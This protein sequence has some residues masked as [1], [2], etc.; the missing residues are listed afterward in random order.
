LI[1]CAAFPWQSSAHAESA[2]PAVIWYRSTAD[3]PDGKSFLDQLAKRTTMARLAAVGD[4]VEFVVTLGKTDNHSVGRLERQSERGT[5]AI[6]EVTGESCEQVADALALTLAL[7]I[8]PGEDRA[9][10]EPA[11]AP[12]RAAPASEA[13]GRETSARPAPRATDRPPPPRRATPQEI[14]TGLRA[15]VA[16]GVSPVALGGG[17]PFFDWHGRSESALAPSVRVGPALLMGS[18]DTSR[19]D[20]KTI[21]LVGRFEGCPL[22]LRAS[23]VRIEPCVG[24]DLGRWSARRTSTT[25]TSRSDFWASFLLTGRVGWVGDWLLLEAHA[26]VGIPFTRYRIV[27]ER[28]HESLYT[29]AALGF[30][31]GVGAGF[32]FR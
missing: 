21:L 20:L 14:A 5:V 8:V 22:S 26:G 30:T 24:L 23:G 18:S 31:G 3:C 25:E 16:T 4:R 7:I 17:G 6:R 9:A 32:V 11:E 28:P 29:V 2:R 1:A 15:L 27:Y 10:E 12:A 13:V 19:G